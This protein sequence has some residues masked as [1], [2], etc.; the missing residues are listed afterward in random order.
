MVTLRFTLQ[1]SIAS[2]FPVVCL[3]EL[4]NTYS[5][6]CVRLGPFGSSTSACPDAAH[7][8]HNH[9]PA[10]FKRSP[11]DQGKRAETGVNTNWHNLSLF[12]RTV[13]H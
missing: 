11:S 12:M 5:T 8:T 13:V 2:F 7:A 1:V 10:I 9:P 3:P 6:V 4:V